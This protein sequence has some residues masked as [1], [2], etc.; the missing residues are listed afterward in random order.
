MPDPTGLL[1]H[2]NRQHRGMAWKEPCRVATTATVTISTALNSGDTI[3]GVTLADGD[4]VLVKDQSTGNQNGIYVVGTTPARAYDMDQDGTTSVVAEEIAGA[5]VW[6]IAGTANAQT[7]WFTT[8]VAG[9]TLGSTTITFSQFT[10]GGGTT[11][12]TKDEGSTLSSTVTTLDFT[13]AGVTASGG[14]ATTTVN[15]P[16]G[17][18]SASPSYLGYNTIGGSTQAMTSQR[19]YCT[20]ITAGG[21]G[22]VLLGIQAYMAVTAEAVVNC[23]WALFAD[24][25]SDTIGDLLSYVT[26][27]AGT[28]ASA[29]LIHATGN[30]PARWWGKPMS[31]ALD[32]S[33]KYWVGVSF[34]GGG[35]NPNLYKDGSG[36]D[37]YYTLGSGPYIGDGT[38]TA[39]T[40]VNTTNKHSIR[41]LVL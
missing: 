5:F 13:G 27:T 32:A 29:A 30:Y 12:T 36:S 8:N 9:G 11:I 2:L 37:R 19:I 33:T 41:A 1:S 28:D 35:G 17:G 15:I 25:G 23:L 38:Y 14:G 40:Q 26:D 3:D 22:N 39:F 24:S 20:Q 21:S 31:W 6:V 4:R 7:L 10:G 34:I 16:G 18:G